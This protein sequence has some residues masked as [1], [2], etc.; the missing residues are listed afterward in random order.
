M[1][2]SNMNV[3]VLKNIIRGYER[4]KKTVGGSGSFGYI[5]FYR[6]CRHSSTTA[7]W[8]C[9]PTVN[10]V[11]TEMLPTI[12]FSLSPTVLELGAEIC[13]SGVQR[14][15]HYAF[16]CYLLPFSCS[17]FEAAKV[18]TATGNFKTSFYS[19]ANKQQR[20]PN[21]NRGVRVATLPRSAP[22]EVRV[23]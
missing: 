8:L 7:P 21:K 16:C 10:R 12:L 17:S 4:K 11:A 1:N 22:L 15:K 19:V 20:R 6:P 3:S 2:T 9:H 14:R 13:F 18:K 23:G 5:R